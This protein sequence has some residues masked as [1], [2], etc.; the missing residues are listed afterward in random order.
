M[1][2]GFMLPTF[3]NSQTTLR[4]KE[5]PM[6]KPRRLFLALSLSVILSGTAFAGETSG[7]PCA[8]P[9]ETSGPPCSSG[10]III[11]ETTEASSNVSDEVETMIFESASYAI[12]SLL[13]LF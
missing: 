10:Q 8:N 12:D 5:K 9:G 1:K 13:T 2:P 6:N 11:D 4:F 7:P 3:K